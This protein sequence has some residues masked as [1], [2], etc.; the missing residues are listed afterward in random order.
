[1]KLNVKKDEFNIPTLIL[2][3][4]YY[5]RTYTRTFQSVLIY[6]QVKNLMIDMWTDF[7]T[8]HNPTPR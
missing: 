3:P 7:A 8:E 2:K 1:M 6:I 4:Y 5:T